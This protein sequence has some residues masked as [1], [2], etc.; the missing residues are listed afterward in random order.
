[1]PRPK[2]D[3]VQIV[4]RVPREWLGKA[5]AIA[6][7]HSHP[8]LSLTRSDGF[9]IAMGEGFSSHEDAFDRQV[10][11]LPPPDGVGFNLVNVRSGGAKR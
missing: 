11:V 1:M 10:T 7:Y 3:R 8:S 4:L 2:T 5:D 9:R 6:K